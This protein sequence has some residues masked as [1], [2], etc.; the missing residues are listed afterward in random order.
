MENTNKKEINLSEVDFSS[1]QEKIEPLSK[2]NISLLFLDEELRKF[3][4]SGLSE[5]EIAIIE[6]FRKIS[7]IIL[8][9]D[10]SN[11]FAPCLQL[12]K[13]ARTCM[14]E[15]VSETEM[16]FFISI[17]DKVSNKMLKARM[18]DILWFRKYK[19]TIDYPKITIGIYLSI[20]FSEPNFF[21]N[22]LFW[23]RGLYLASQ[24]RDNDIFKQFEKKSIKFL[25][26][27]KF[28]NNA[29]FLRFIEVLRA[30]KLC[31][32]STDSI[33]EQ[34][35]KWGS[36]LEQKRNH[37]L[38]EQYYDEASLWTL[39]ILKN[40]NRYTE[41]QINRVLAYIN[42]AETPENGLS[43]S[44][45]YETALRILRALDRKQRELYFSLEKE[46]ELIQ[47]IKK[48]G[49]F[50]I[51]QMCSTSFSF[52]MS[53]EIK[54]ITENIRGKDIETALLN[55]ISLMGYISFVKLEKNAID[56]IKA[57]PL[58][59]F[60]GHTVF[61]SDGRIISK[62]N[63][64]NNFDELNYKNP[65]VWNNMVWQYMLQISCVVQSA[66][67]P[68]LQIIRCEHNILLTDLIDI[69]RKSNLIPIDR[70]AVF[71]KGLYAG[72]SYDFITSLH[73]LVPQIENMVRVQLQESGIRT[74][75]IENT[76]DIENEEGLSTLV[77]KDGFE[78][79][80]GKDLGF[81]IKAL[82][83]DGAGPNLRNN[84]AHGLLSSTEM[85]SIYSVYCWWFCFKLVYISFYNS[86]REVL[87]I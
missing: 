84:V 77:K 51:S 86:K 27:E 60:F 47:N 4:T 19:K 24:I 83:C 41:I 45:N 36:E 29:C 59:S 64:I 46:N 33:I 43:A 21:E 82:F 65:S 34:L 17:L 9:D 62:T 55:F 50:S 71:A 30:F 5:T 39:Q 25:F 63:G 10:M 18:A 16:D 74:S 20:D 49:K 2:T 75:I 66:I 69:V 3:D 70:I 28:N 32:E 38:A 44:S 72:F 11:P 73:L 54:Y 13:G 68:A 53:D 31:S 57:S 8:T 1:F 79:I 81:E 7:S 40:S 48:T 37:F 58:V 80:F 23:R 6:L 85:S 12:S 61:G 22:I 15:D 35:L 52:D 78:D 14:P 87:K 67:L 56:F 76:T 26:N 42:A